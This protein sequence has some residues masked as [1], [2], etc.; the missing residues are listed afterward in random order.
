MG[1]DDGLLIPGPAIVEIIRDNRPICRRFDFSL[2]MVRMLLPKAQVAEDA[3]YDVGFMNQTD[4]LHFMAAS[5][6]TKGGP[7]PRSS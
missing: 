7:L 6:A 2:M 5:R 1:D 3:F 4:D